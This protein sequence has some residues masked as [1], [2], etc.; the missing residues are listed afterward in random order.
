MLIIDKFVDAEKNQH[1]E[2]FNS[3]QG[4]TALGTVKAN[5]CKR[6]QDENFHFISSASELKEK[7][8]EGEREPH[9]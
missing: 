6:I 2:G 4:G 3:S 5:C 8:R 7:E 9:P 1:P